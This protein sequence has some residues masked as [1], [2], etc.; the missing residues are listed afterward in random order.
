[1]C[2][3]VAYTHDN[4]CGV[5]SCSCRKDLLLKYEVKYEAVQMQ[6]PKSRNP[7]RFNKKHSWKQAGSAKTA[8]SKFYLLEC[9]FDAIGYLSKRG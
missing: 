9:F 8:S 7:A 2:S 3:N 1:M 6:T 4:D 5:F